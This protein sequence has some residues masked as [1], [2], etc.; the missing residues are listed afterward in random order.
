MCSLLVV[1][2]FGALAFRVT[3][4]QVLSGDRYRECRSG[5][6]STTVPLPAQRGTIFDRNGRD[7]AMSIELTSI[8]AD[9]K[10]VT[11]DD[12]LRGRARADPARQPQRICSSTLFRP[13]PR[14]RVPR[15]HG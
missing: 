8:Y 5:R 10:H 3:Q 14:L 15:A 7:L 13:P 6:R 4:L 2:V 12:R 11:D 9:P 1:V